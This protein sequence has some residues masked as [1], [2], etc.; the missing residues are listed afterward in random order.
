MSVAVGPLTIGP[1]RNGVPETG[2]GCKGPG[3]AG[4]ELIV[5]AEE[6]RPVGV[7]VTREAVDPSQVAV[8]WFERQRMGRSEPLDMT[9]TAKTVGR[10]AF[11]PGACP[12]QLVS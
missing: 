5:K 10:A 12:Y 9:K 3:D 8:P 7:I 2:N 6:T 1:V 4:E 11:D